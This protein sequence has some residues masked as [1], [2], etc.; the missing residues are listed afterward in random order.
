MFSVLDAALLRP[1]PYRDG[2]SLVVAGPPNQTGGAGETSEPDLRDWQQRS[3]AF[4]QLAYCEPNYVGMQLPRQS[5]MVSETACS[6]NLFSL[7]GAA[8]A[9]GRGFIPADQAGRAQVAVLSDALWRTYFGASPAAVGQQIKLGEKDY[10][11]VGVMPAGFSYPLGEMNLW[12]PYAPDTAMAAARDD[13]RLQVIG[14]LRPGASHRQAQAELSGIQAGIARRFPDK[15]LASRVVVESYRDQLVARVR[16]AMEALSGAVALV[17]LI[18]CVAV[19]G[20]LL[21]RGAVRRRELAVRTA[22]GASH[23]RLVSQLLA[24]SLLLSGLACAAG[25]AVAW[26]GIAA[27]GRFLAGH[28]PPGMK[29]HASW[30]VLGGLAG[31]TLVSVLLIGLLPA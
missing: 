2:G 15:K 19:A 31:L 14:R 23:R 21:T 30:G 25:A 9:L 8:P 6:A 1:L 27:V 3:R 22:L 10:T 17:W 24:E 16:P 20:L 7:L 29:V 13:Y 28:M 4:S 12:T 5:A 26:A 11:V 18:A